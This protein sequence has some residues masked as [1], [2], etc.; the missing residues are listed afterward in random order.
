[1]FKQGLPFHIEKHLKRVIPQSFHLKLRPLAISLTRRYLSLLNRMTRPNIYRHSSSER[2]G[3]VYD[4]PSEMSIDERIMLYS[5]VRGCRPMRVLEIGTSAG[6]SAAII[7][8]AMED[9]GVGCLVGVDPAPNITVN[10]RAFHSRFHL[11]R[12]PSPEA[13]AEACEYAGG[14]FEFVLIDGLHIYKQVIR[15]IDGCLPHL[16][17]GAYLLFH[18][19]YHPGVRDAIQTTLNTHSEFHDCGYVAGSPS[20]SYPL[21]AYQGLQLVR[22]DSST[23]VDPLPRIAAAYSAA[24]KPPPPSDSDLRNHDE[25]YCRVHKP[26]DYCLKKKYDLRPDDTAR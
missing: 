16:T 24:G 25:W 26:C 8:S 18:D 12:K 15:D 5:L 6:G 14:T 3:V 4:N 11:I 23:I 1:M 20:T 13:I 17:H 2:I 10:H 9:N 22:Y 21:V 19:A 7:T